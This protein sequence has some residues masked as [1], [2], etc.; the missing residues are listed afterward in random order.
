VRLDFFGDTLDGCARFDAATQRT[1]E[2]LDAVEF[3]RCRR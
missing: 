2:K 1:T 3:A